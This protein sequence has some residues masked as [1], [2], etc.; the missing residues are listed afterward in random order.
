MPCHKI[1]LY[2]FA[3]SLFSCVQPIENFVQKD[4]NSYVTIEA[5]IADDPELCKVRLSSS[6]NRILSVLAQPIT[7]AEVYVMDDKGVKTFFKEVS[8]PLGTYLPPPEFSGKIGSS[9]KLFVKT[10]TG[11]QYESSTETIRAV[12]EIENA[13]VRFEALEQYTKVDPRRAGFTVYLD[14]K[15][16][17]S[18]GDYYMWNW[19]HYEQPQFCATCTDG[20][21]FD[22]VKT[23]DCV[24]PRF[25]NNNIFIKLV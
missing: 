10:L 16:N 2:L 23:L 19:K 20:G 25:P 24:L 6:A 13:I 15:D 12:P 5:D 8:K 7:K 1:I 17:A 4:S 14:F 3:L 9:Y 22:F 11:N 18:E 21:R